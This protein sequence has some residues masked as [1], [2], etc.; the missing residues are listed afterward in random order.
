MVNKVY[1]DIILLKRVQVTINY[2]DKKSVS[3][4]G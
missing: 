2:A 4:K 3:M 1:V